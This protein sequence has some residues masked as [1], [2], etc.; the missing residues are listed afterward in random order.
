MKSNKKEEKWYYDEHEKDKQQ[1]KFGK[2]QTFEAIHSVQTY[3][4]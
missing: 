4:T 3:Q 2:S 1:T